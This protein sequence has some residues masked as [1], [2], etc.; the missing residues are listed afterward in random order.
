MAGPSLA[1]LSRKAYLD[2]A[3][4]LMNGAT[5]DPLGVR[6][7]DLLLFLLLLFLVYYYYQLSLFV[8]LFVIL[9]L[10]CFACM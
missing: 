4:W 6:T 9:Y 2:S 5:V 7:L 10:W 1:V 8:L 3:I